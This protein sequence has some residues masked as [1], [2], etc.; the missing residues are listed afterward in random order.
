MYDLLLG[1]G[2]M[3]VV[4][5]PAAQVTQAV[6][7][8]SDMQQQQQQRMVWQSTASRIAAACNTDAL[9]AAPDKACVC[10]NALHGQ[11]RAV[12]VTNH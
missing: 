3:V 4:E 5:V 7:D 9:A 1:Q 11:C 12:T 8:S 10:Y 6:V 2:S